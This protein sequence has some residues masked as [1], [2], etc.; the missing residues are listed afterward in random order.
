MC[1]LFGFL[2]YSQDSFN[3][4]NKL[5]NALAKQAI[6]RGTDSAG[7]AYN[8]GDKLIIYKEPKSANMID[9]KHHDSAVCVTGHTRHATQ[10]DK[11]KNFNNHPFGGS[12]RNL[13]FAL[14]HNGVLVNAE[15]L[16]REY[17]LPKTK[18]ETDSYVAV[19]LLER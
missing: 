17:N 13:R 15:E 18:I 3:N 9:F 7:I 1:C 10:G 16:K 6:A 5:T 14:S 19:Q 11:R 12:C 4:L 2:N 8:S